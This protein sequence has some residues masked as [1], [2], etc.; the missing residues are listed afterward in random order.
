MFKQGID[1]DTIK[2]NGWFYEKITAMCGI[3]FVLT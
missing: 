3:V 2:M 1:Q